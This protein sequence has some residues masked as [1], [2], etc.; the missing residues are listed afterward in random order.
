MP[1]ICVGPDPAP[2]PN[3]ITLNQIVA[4]NVLAGGNGAFQANRNLQ[5]AG[6]VGLGVAPTLPA[7]CSLAAYIVNNQ[8]FN[9]GNHRTGVLVVHAGSVFGRHVYLRTPMYQTYAIL[10]YGYYHSQVGN[11][12]AAGNQVVTLANNAG[13]RTYECCNSLVARTQSVAAA[14][15]TLPNLLEDIGRF[16]RRGWN[17]A[18]PI[19]RSAE[20]AG[21]A[22]AETN[23]RLRGRIKRFRQLHGGTTEH[24]ADM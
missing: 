10:D 7:L 20:F 15:A 8:I 1:C 4:W 19:A 17:Q 18:Y 11:F 12:V 9:D 3:N 2:A 6:R 16:G 23:L 21:L 14:V 22:G 5:L 24:A 13:R